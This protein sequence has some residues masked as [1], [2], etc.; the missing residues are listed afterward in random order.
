MPPIPLFREDGGTVSPPPLLLYSVS[1]L[2]LVSS[3]SV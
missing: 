2:G 3:Q 1:V